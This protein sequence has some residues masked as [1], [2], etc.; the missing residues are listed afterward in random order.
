[1]PLAQSR[2]Y[3]AYVADH[4]RGRAWRVGEY[5]GLVTEERRP[6]REKLRA[7]WI[8]AALGAVCLVFLIGMIIAR[9]ELLVGFVVFVPLSVCM[10][11]YTAV[12]FGHQ[13]R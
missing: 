4:D 11:V 5:L 9:F 13:R 12:A 8:Y 3:P 6:F 10:L 2:P 1:V 7:W